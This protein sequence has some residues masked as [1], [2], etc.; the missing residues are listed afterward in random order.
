MHRSGSVALQ[1]AAGLALAGQ[2]VLD[3]DVVLLVPALAAARHNAVVPGPG[4][5]YDGPASVA[6]SDG[7]DRVVVRGEVG[8]LHPLQ[9]FLPPA[10]AGL[11]AVA[12]EVEHTDVF[13]SAAVAA[14]QDRATSTLG[15]DDGQ[16]AEPVAGLRVAGAHVTDSSVPTESWEEG[17]EMRQSYL[18]RIGRARFR[19]CPCPGCGL[20]RE[21]LANFRA[22]QRA[23]FRSKREAT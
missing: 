17:R 20:R 9:S 23:K 12:D 7:H 16:L 3:D 10:S 19:R 5:G 1:A 13:L 11:G 15:I 14:T 8:E 18:I 4:L 2:Q 21:A 6:R 22:G